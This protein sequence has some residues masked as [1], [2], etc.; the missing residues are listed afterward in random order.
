MSYL[1]LILLIENVTFWEKLLL[2][3]NYTQEDIHSNFFNL[4]DKIII[5]YAIKI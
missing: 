4:I 5:L 3:I 1:I 2:E